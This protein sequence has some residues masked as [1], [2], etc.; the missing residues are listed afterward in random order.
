MLTV[1]LGYQDK[2]SCSLSAYSGLDMRVDKRGQSCEMERKE[3][4]GQVD[5]STSLS[6]PDSSIAAWKVRSCLTSGIALLHLCLCCSLD[7]AAVEVV[8]AK[9]TYN[10]GTE[11]VE[12]SGTV[13]WKGKKGIRFLVASSV[14][15]DG[16]RWVEEAGRR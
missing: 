16:R 3:E 8:R 10:N 7:K 13:R 4:G 5:Q 2:D 6:L 1:S 14:R 11:K 12:G 9:G 15:Q